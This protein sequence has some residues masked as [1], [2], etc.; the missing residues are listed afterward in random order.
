[1][2]PTVGSVI[3]PTKPDAF[4]KARSVRAQFGAKSFGPPAG[5]VHEIEAGFSNGGPIAPLS[6]K[7]QCSGFSAKK[8][9]SIVHSQES[10]K[11]KGPS[12]SP[13]RK[14]RSWP[15]SLKVSPFALKHNLDGGGSV[16]ANLAIF[17]GSSVSNK[18]VLSPVPKTSQDFIGETE[19]DKGISRCSLVNKVCPPISAFSE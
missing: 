19:G 16:E 5:P 12:V 6:S 7:L 13:R 15:P 11:L 2:G 10:S 8:V 18:G 14:V 9:T 4:F 1:M 17:R 3:G